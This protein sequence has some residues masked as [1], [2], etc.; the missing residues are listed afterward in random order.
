[1]PPRT[2]RPLVPCSGGSACIAARLALPPLP[3]AAIPEA[4]DTHV[5]NPYVTLDP[6]EPSQRDLCGLVLAETTTYLR[7]RP[8]PPFRDGSGNPMTHEG[9]LEYGR[10]VV[11]YLT[12]Q[13]KG[14]ARRFPGSTSSV[15][16][17]QA[18]RD[19]TTRHKALRAQHTV[20]DP[21]YIAMLDELLDDLV[22]PAY[23]P[24]HRH[25]ALEPRYVAIL[26]SRTPAAMYMRMQTYDPYPDAPLPLRNHAWDQPKLRQWLRFTPLVLF[27]TRE[28]DMPLLWRRSQ[29]GVNKGILNH[30]ES[31]VN[32]IKTRL[33]S[34]VRSSNDRLQFIEAL[35]SGSAWLTS[36]PA[37]DWYH[38]IPPLAQKAFSSW[39]VDLHNSTRASLAKAGGLITL[40]YLLAWSPERV[41]N[42][43]SL[44][45]TGSELI[46]SFT[47]SFRFGLALWSRSPD[48]QACCVAFPRAEPKSEETFELDPTEFLG[49][50]TSRRPSPSTPGRRSAFTLQLS[51]FQSHRA[52]STASMD[53][54]ITAELATLDP[55]KACEQELCQLVINETPP[56]PISQAWRDW[57]A[58]HEALEPLQQCADSA[59]VAALDELLSD[60]H[61][62]T[63]EEDWKPAASEAH[64]V[65]ILLSRTPM[66]MYMRMQSHNPCPDAPESLREGLWDQPKLRTWIRFAPQL[67]FSL[68]LL[69][70]AMPLPWSEADHM[71]GTIIGCIASLAR[72]I[73]QHLSAE[74]RRFHHPGPS[75]SEMPQIVNTGIAWITSTVVRDWYTKAHVT[76]QRAF[77]AWVLSVYHF[78]KTGLEK[79]GGLITLSSLAADLYPYFDRN[80]L[81]GVRTAYSTGWIPVPESS[82]TSGH[83]QFMHAHPEFQAFEA[84]PHFATSVARTP[85]PA[86]HARYKGPNGN[87]AR[88]TLSNWQAC[89]EVFQPL[90]KNPLYIRVLEELLRDLESQHP[91][92]DRE[93]YFV[94]VLCLTSLV[95]SAVK[96][97]NCSIAKYGV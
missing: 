55:A 69:E 6:A 19:W 35:D 27:P 42:W 45:K 70:D 26:L 25:A 18:C 48:T 92:K 53:P 8:L 78:L 15:T 87:W 36:G 12:N 64:Y 13:L 50:R 72:S 23:E 1:M 14:L 83:H 31:L 21:A 93:L 63:S 80:S 4:M 88:E 7:R 82:S 90:Y 86:Y 20:Q 11:K 84:L 39:I 24:A 60:L 57:Q 29:H 61:A 76:T 66:A 38:R 30:I 59:Y 79:S 41:Q 65:S 54:R 10:I 3:A 62:Q 56:V 77:S 40:S 89:K 96:D 47:H 94:A 95:L 52:A 22:R 43:M 68:P 49:P 71:Q 67:R 44:I 51:P 37:S 2:A 17:G 58:R 73:K 32:Y 28:I 85:A 16:I 33:E 5:R 74:V 97:S 75:R 81:H 91:H 46:P 34:D 9:V